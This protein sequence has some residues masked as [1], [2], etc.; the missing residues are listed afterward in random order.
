MK[1][2]MIEY[3][4]QPPVETPL[5]QYANRL[6]GEYNE[7]LSDLKAI[8]NYLEILTQ[9]IKEIKVL[10]EDDKARMMQP[11]LDRELLEKSRCTYLKESLE[12]MGYVL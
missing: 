10:G 8:R 4:P 9:E 7:S 2:E 11:L 12:E 3:N 6:F 1:N 5:Q